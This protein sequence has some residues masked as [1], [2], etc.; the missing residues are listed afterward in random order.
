MRLSLLELPT[1]IRRALLVAGLPRGS[2]D[3]AAR[4][5]GWAE[6]EQGGALAWLERQLPGLAARPAGPLDAE[7]LAAGAVRL[8]GRQQSFLLT[9]PPALDM[10]TVAARR[11]GIGATLVA[12]CAGHP[13]LLALADL[14]A[15]RGLIG[16][17]A[18]AGTDGPQAATTLPDGS[19]PWRF[20]WS[21]G[22]AGSLFAALVAAATGG[23]PRVG[24]LD[25]LLALMRP[26]AAA[27]GAV[28]GSYAVLCADPARFDGAG[29]IMAAM[30]V[31]I[32][33]A[34]VDAGESHSPSDQA[35]R[36]A[37]A[38]TEGI[39]VD[40]ALW[41][42]LRAYGDRVLIPNSERSRRGAG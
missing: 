42:R 23:L 31:E 6:I 22:E 14:A 15:R 37:L 17:V 4:L 40:E 28:D 9:G 20:D 25:D 33:Q 8:H 5:I 13:P 35:L 18:F 16:V 11:H 12:D 21:G 7:P 19:Q 3:A 2:A 1:L 27:G 10:A 41:L 29:R 30:L 32:D 26:Q 24:S 36:H 34:K 39:E 38:L